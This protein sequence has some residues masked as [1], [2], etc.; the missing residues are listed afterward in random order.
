LTFGRSSGALNFRVRSIWISLI[1]FLLPFFFGLREYET[2]F[3]VFCQEKFLPGMALFLSGSIE[4][5]SPLLIQYHTALKQ[6]Q[7]LW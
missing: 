7:K 2:R 1:G 6:C 4:A 3:F 5:H